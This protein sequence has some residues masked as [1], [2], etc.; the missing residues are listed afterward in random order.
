MLVLVTMVAMDGVQCYINDV[1]LYG[2]NQ[3][4]IQWQ[5]VFSL[6]SCPLRY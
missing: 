5:A 6:V 3:Q 1:A 4:A 2:A